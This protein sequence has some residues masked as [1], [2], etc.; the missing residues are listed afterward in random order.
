MASRRAATI[1]LTRLASGSLGIG[2]Q[3][4]LIGLQRVAFERGS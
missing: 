1:A 3:E 4:I 2:G